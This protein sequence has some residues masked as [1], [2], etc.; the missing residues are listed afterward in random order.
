MRLRITVVAA[1]VGAAALLSHYGVAW[2]QVTDFQERGSDFSTYYVAALLIREGHAS[3][4]YDQVLEQ[5]RHLALLPPGTRLT[6]PFVTPPTTALLALPLSFMDLVAASRL[7][8]VIEVVLLAAAIVVAVRAAPWPQHLGRGPRS[9]VAALAFAGIPTYVLLLLGQLDGV[10]AL[11]LAGGYAAWRRGSPGWAGFWLALGFLATKPHLAAGLLLFLL[12][13]REWKALGGFA[14]ATGVVVAL[15]L[16]VVGPG[17]LVQFLLGYRYSLGITPEVSTLGLPG[18]M[19]SW[20]GTGVAAQALEV[21]SVVAGLAVCAAFGHR[22]RRPGASLEFSLLGAVAVSLMLSPHL[23]SYDL[24]VMAPLFV[25]CMARAAAA[26]GPGVWPGRATL[27]GVAAWVC[28]NLLVN[29]DVGNAASAPPG[30]VT[31]LAL[32]IAAALAWRGLSG[33]RQPRALRR[34]APRRLQLDSGSGVG[35]SVE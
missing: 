17:G 15:S 11:G 4:L 32:L 20:L 19:A 33:G 14:A 28:G 30:R 3:Q 2:L 23:F 6:L 22:S 13:R 7:F 1:V 34:S 8:S 25:V 21:V 10:C 9:A 18:L 16:P 35:G 12:F 27:V 24:V 31:P 5:Q 26:D 29:A